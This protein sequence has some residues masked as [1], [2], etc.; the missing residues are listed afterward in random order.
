MKSRRKKFNKHISAPTEF[1]WDRTQQ[2]VVA[3]GYGKAGS[4]RKMRRHSARSIQRAR[5]QNK[6]A[7]N[8]V[9]KLIQVERDGQGQATR[10]GDKFR[11]H[12]KSA[13]CGHEQKA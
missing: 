13:S 9:D 1:Y 12:A 11:I 7:D 2:T 4:G 5:N 6:A 10:V 3:V 8:F